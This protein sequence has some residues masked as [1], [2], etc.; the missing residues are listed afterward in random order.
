MGSSIITNAAVQPLKQASSSSPLASYYSRLWELIG[1]G[2]VWDRP[3]R[4]GLLTLFGFW[5]AR[6]YATWETWGSLTIDCG[7]EMYVA[8]ALAEGKM[9]YRDVWY[10]YGPAAPYFN[11]YLFRW[12]GT[13]LNVLY[14]AGSISALVCAL[15]LFLI[16][17]QFSSRLVGWT[18]AIV[19]LIEAFHAG[20]F[21]FPLP[22]SFASVYGCLAAC[23]FLWLAIRAVR[24]PNW[25][26]LFSAGTVAA[27]AFILKLEFGAACYATLALLIAL[28]C[29]QR[30]SWQPLFPGILAVLPGITACIAVIWWMVSIRGVDFI[31]QE[32]LMSWPTSYF[33]KTYGRMWFATTGLSIDGMA[34]ALAS[35]RTMLL[36]LV[37][38]RSFRFLRSTKRH[39]ALILEVAALTVIA[40]AFVLRFLPTWAQDA[41][42]WIFFPQ[43]TVLY[44]AIAALTIC[45]YL[46]RNP[47]SQKAAGVMI[48]FSFSA[49]LAA[50]I[51]L[52][53]KPSGYPM[54]YSGPAILSFLLIAPAL[55][56]R[57][58]I[59]GAR[60][61]ICVG[62]VCAA[63][64]H[65]ATLPGGGNLVPLAT[66]R[67]TIRVSKNVAAN[68]QIAIAFMKEKA[69]LGQPVMSIPEDTS[70][71]LAPGKM[72]KEVI[73]EIEHAHVRYLIWSNRIFPEYGV[74][75]FG[76]D[77]DR[78]MGDYFK[79]HY[80]FL[81]PLSATAPFWDWNGGIWER[82]ADAEFQ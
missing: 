64:L 73:G 38:L 52:G 34:I 1:P 63:A 5:A 7:R 66:D 8:S 30:R 71:Y 44:V 33:V 49:L 4:F 20:I 37:G 75:T 35:V 77:Y 41:F 60:M 58:H 2:I 26:W 69:A 53:M 47:G 17:G 11:S 36:V 55:F 57:Q 23:L 18:A 70:L 79:A 40:L 65:S 25:I 62:F 51:L 56:P 67:G 9:L 19:V 74:P 80:R 72:T 12:F 39:P 68:Y 14:W 13:N 16:G 32:N 61:L 82:R 46:W 29:F 22:Y 31:T 48:L 27:A 76:W 50:R 6:M 42:R 59:F 10:T 78:T 81:R 43:D 21:C 24:S 15:L 45:W 3:T 28:R 54:Y